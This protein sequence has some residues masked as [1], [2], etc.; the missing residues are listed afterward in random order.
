MFSTIMSKF[1]NENICLK[2]SNL[3]NIRQDIVAIGAIHK[4]KKTISLR[5]SLEGVNKNSSQFPFV[6]MRG[7][8]SNDRRHFNMVLTFN[9]GELLEAISD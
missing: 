1:D 9:K 6:G 8:P 2:A 4:T 5:Y 3:L 7:K